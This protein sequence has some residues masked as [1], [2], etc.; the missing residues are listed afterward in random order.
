[1]KNVKVKTFFASKMSKLEE[2]INVF[3]NETIED[4]D[5]I[6]IK[7]NTIL[8]SDNTYCHFALVMYL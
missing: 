8:D 3:I 6:D 1:M 2:S 7:I 4:C 5:V